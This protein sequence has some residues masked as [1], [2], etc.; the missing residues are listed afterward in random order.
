[1]LGVRKHLGLM[2]PA[3]VQAAMVAALGDEGHV[4]AQREVYRAR[5]EV[6]RAAL[7]AAGYRIDHSEAGLYLWATKDAAAWE[8]VGELA[9]SGI[10]AVPGTFYGDAT[11]VRLALTASD[12]AMAETARRL[13]ET[14]K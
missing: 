1:V 2:T 13:K 11:H 10:L 4:V 8:S 9:E 14:S 7:E 3:P 5:R 12:A 6:L